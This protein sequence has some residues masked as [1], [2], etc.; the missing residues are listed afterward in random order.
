MLD[1]RTMQI[2]T[3]EQVAERDPQGARGRAG[4]ARHLTTDCGMKPLPRMVAKMKLKAL[5]DGA[6]IVRERR[7]KSVRAGAAPPGRGACAVGGRRMRRSPASERCREPATSAPTAGAPSPAARTRRE[8]T[9]TPS[10]PASAAAA[11][12]AGVEMP[13]PSATGTRGRGA[14]ARE[15]RRDAVGAAAR[16]RR[17]SR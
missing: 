17:S 12:C 2:E 3:P 7:L 6:A 13:K 16:A 14:R 1:I 8:P 5:A 9:I 10:A 11:A 15:Q 4:R